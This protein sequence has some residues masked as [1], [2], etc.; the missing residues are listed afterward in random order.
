MRVRLV[1]M[2][3]IGLKFDIENGYLVCKDLYFFIILIIVISK[4]QINHHFVYLTIQNDK[5]FKQIADV[6]NSF[7]VADDI[8]VGFWNK[9]PL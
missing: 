8:E 9:I 2:L 6:K 4:I 3:V 5:S 1:G 7:V